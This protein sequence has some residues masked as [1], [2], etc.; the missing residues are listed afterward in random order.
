MLFTSEP[1]EFSILALFLLEGVC[2]VSL[3]LIDFLLDMRKINFVIKK[4]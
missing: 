2:G 1:K 4:L 3:G